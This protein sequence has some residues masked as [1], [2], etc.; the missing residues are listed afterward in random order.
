MVPGARRARRPHLARSKRAGYAG[1]RGVWP[2]V[3]STS[4][5]DAIHSRLRYTGWQSSRGPDIGHMSG[6]RWQY[7][8]RMVRLVTTAARKALRNAIIRLPSCSGHE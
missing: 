7:F 5:A 1:R 8:H 3:G 2:S 4:S 6:S